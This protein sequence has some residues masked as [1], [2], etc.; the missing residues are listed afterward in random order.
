MRPRLPQGCPKVARRLP[1]GCPKVAP[2]LRRSIFLLFRILASDVLDLNELN[3]A[4]PNCPYMLSDPQ[5]RAPS[6]Q[7]PGSVGQPGSAAAQAQ[8]FQMVSFKRVMAPD[9]AWRSTPRAMSLHHNVS[10]PYFWAARS[11]N[12]VEP[13]AALRYVTCRIVAGWRA[14]SRWRW[15]RRHRTRSAVCSRCRGTRWPGHCHV[16]SPYEAPTT[17]CSDFGVVALMSARTFHVSHAANSCML[18]ITFLVRLVAAREVPCSG[19][20]SRSFDSC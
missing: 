17:V 10:D 11:E 4:A 19:S 13:P 8:C 18:G 1:E 3:A 16:A 5:R 15:R 7:R 2:R 12:I 9:G 20:R 6:L 14:R